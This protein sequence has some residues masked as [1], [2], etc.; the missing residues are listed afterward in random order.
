VGASVD[1][2]ARKNDEIESPMDSNRRNALQTLSLS[3]LSSMAITLPSN[4]KSAEAASSDL[5]KPNPL[6][7]PVLEQVRIWNQDEADNIRYGGELESGSAKP[8]AFEQYV[9]LLQPILTVEHELSSI[10][11]LLNG[12]KQQPASNKEEYTALFEKISSILSQGLFDKIAF[13]KAFNAF[14]DNIYYSDPDRANLYLGGG[15][16]PKTTQSLAYLVRN[17]VLTNVEDMRAEVIYLLK[18]VGK[19]GDGDVVTA[20]ELELDEIMKMNRAANE[21]MV[22]YLGLVPPQELEA[23][24]A[25][26]ASK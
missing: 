13:K 7:N 6:T 1:L 22:K 10:D 2:H 17:D 14:A 20:A 8:A 19:K 15:A 18:E 12:D 24:R 23:A 5:F 25:A 11:Q 9:Q 21:G 4:P 3:L 16:V 26:F